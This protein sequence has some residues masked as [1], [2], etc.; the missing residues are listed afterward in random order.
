MKNIFLLLK[1]TEMK[2]QKEQ[3]QYIY[4]YIYRERERESTQ[5]NIFNL[6][7]GDPQ[8]K[9]YKPWHITETSL[10]HWTF[11][12]TFS[13]KWSVTISEDLEMSQET[14]FLS[15]EPFQSKHYYFPQRSWFQI[16]RQKCHSLLGQGPNAT[17]GKTAMT[18][19]QNR[20]KWNCFHQANDS[21][22]CRTL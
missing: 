2:K 5:F 16:V 6:L 12:V 3:N 21:S 7:T 1:V 22:W 20:G 18:L 13:F 17:A 9:L 15:H 19:D 10:L 8:S 11:P 14:I 4:I